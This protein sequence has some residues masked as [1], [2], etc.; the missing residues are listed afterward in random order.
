MIISCLSL[1]TVPMVKV[2]QWTYTLSRNEWIFMPTHELCFLPEKISLFFLNFLS[3]NIMPSIWPAWANY[4]SLY[5]A[6]PSVTSSSDDTNLACTRFQSPY[7]THGKR[8]LSTQCWV[9]WTQLSDAGDELSYS[10]MGFQCLTLL[11]T[12]W[13][14][15]ISMWTSSLILYM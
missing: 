3:M 15:R 10:W 9:L 7:S 13:L 1:T 12:P 11:G 5:P 2:P 14:I 6:T 8:V 4:S